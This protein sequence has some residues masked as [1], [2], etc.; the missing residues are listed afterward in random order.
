MARLFAEQLGD[1]E[2]VEIVNDVVL[3]QVLVSFGDD[4][5]TDRVVERVQQDGVCWAGATTWRERRLMRISVSSWLTTAADVD[6]CVQS[7][8]AAHHKR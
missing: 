8:I 3:N 6:A 4:A 2:G 1:V 7:M 5:H